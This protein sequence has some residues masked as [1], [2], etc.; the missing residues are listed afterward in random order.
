VR[1]ELGDR[2]Q[3]IRF[4]H[5]LARG[6]RFERL[7]FGD[8]DQRR[9]SVES[10]LGAGVPGDLGEARLLVD[11]LEVTG[12]ERSAGAVTDGDAVGGLLELPDN[13]AHDLRV[14]GHAFVGRRPD[15]R[16]DL[17]EDRLAL[18]RESS[19]PAEQ[20]KKSGDLRVHELPVVTPALLER[21]STVVQ[22]SSPSGAAVPG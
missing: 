2:H 18:V 5:R 12:G 21:D 22:R 7:A 17:Q 1:L 19:R 14:R 9:R 6:H 8:L 11:A 4:H 16:V 20:V 13:G 15:E 3:A 10:E